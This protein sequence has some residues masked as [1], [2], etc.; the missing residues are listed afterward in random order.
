MKDKNDPAWRIMPSPASRL[1]M[2]EEYLEVAKK[3]YDEAVAIFS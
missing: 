1:M 2:C 3:A